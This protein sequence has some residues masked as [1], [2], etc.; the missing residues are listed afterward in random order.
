MRYGRLHKNH[1]EGST[2]ISL[3]SPASIEPVL[4]KSG[5]QHREKD[6]NPHRLRQHEHKGATQIV[7]EVLDSKY[8][9][10]DA[11]FDFYKIIFF[12]S[13]AQAST[14]IEAWTPQK[15]FSCSRKTSRGLR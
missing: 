3:F 10:I 4:S 12:F 5:S 11:K 8:F 13:Y 14:R 9:C 2:Q 1:E 7:S 15:Y 6:T